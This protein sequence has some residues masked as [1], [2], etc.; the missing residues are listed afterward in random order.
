[1]KILLKA[2]E[3]WR[4]IDGMKVKPKGNVVTLLAYMKKENKALKLLVQSLFDSQ[5]MIMRGKKIMKRI[6]EAYAKCH[7]DKGLANK[8]FLTYKFF[9]SQM[10][11]IDTM[12]VH[13]NKLVV[14]ANELEAIKRQ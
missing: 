14:I 12:E 6:W 13:L 11:P 2:K 8:I 4:F 9:V 1:M 7:V 5:L 10:M 3:L